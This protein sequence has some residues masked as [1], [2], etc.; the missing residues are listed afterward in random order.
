MEWLLTFLRSID[1][2]KN[3]LQPLWQWLFKSKTSQTIDVPLDIPNINYDLISDLCFKIDRREQITCFQNAIRQRNKKHPFI[4]II[5]GN[6][7]GCGD[8]LLDYI[9]DTSLN[10]HSQKPAQYYIDTHF[11]QD[12]AE[13]CD[14]L[15]LGD[16]INNVDDYTLQKAWFSSASNT[17]LKDVKKQFIAT[18]SKKSHPVLFY[19]SMSSQVLHT[20]EGKEKL[21][22]FIKF[23]GSCS[24]NMGKTVHED[25]VLLVCLKVTYTEKCYS[26]IPI[27]KSGQPKTFIEQLDLKKA[28]CQGIVLPELST[29]NKTHLATWI[30]KYASQHC[31]TVILKQH[32]DFLRNEHDELSMQE[33]APKLQNVLIQSLIQQRQ[34]K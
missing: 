19:F 23:W 18:F 13:N 2:T 22:N 28:G 8:K 34:F 11:F 4:F 26:W 6:E 21:D 20:T 3:I 16:I 30:D 29:V 10:F 17:A 5:H 14:K 25:N 31:D 32:I 12:N 9:H 24:R 15:L 33:I 1:T 27:L 7:S